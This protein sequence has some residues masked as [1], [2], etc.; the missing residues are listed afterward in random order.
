MGEDTFLAAQSVI[1]QEKGKMF[2]N[3][4][5]LTLCKIYNVNNKAADIYCFHYYIDEIIK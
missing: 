1:F 4:T 3:I 5:I 2:H